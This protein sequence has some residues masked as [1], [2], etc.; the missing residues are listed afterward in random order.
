MVLS[1]SSSYNLLFEH[2]DNM[3]KSSEV[4]S[5]CCSVFHQTLI[6]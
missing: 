2:Y 3:T 4:Q 1:F 5:A 6:T